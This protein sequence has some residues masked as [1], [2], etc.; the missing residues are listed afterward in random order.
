MGLGQNSG[1]MNFEPAENRS[2]DLS[3]STIAEQSIVNTIMQGGAG[4]EEM[5]DGGLRFIRYLLSI[6]R[7]ARFGFLPN[8]RDLEAVR[9]IA[10]QFIRYCGS[11][12]VAL[13]TMNQVLE[14]EAYGTR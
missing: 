11:A 5:S 8:F 3:L 4:A 1:D 13:Y 6:S 12:A 2:L 7:A 9:E 14:G 10:R